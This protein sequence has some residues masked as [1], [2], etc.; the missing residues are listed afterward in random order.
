M[1]VWLLLKFVAIIMI[2][3]GIVS[4]VIFI[5]YFIW[6]AFQPK[7]ELTAEE[8]KARQQRYEATQ[9]RRRWYDT[10]AAI[11][12][13][14]SAYRLIGTSDFSWWQIILSLSV[15]VFAVND[16]LITFAHRRSEPT[17]PQ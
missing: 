15:S 6:S 16:W 13:T 7:V 2:A 5:G 14:A 17:E 8:K 4:A 10:V 12:L 11:L 3:S 1:W 9:M